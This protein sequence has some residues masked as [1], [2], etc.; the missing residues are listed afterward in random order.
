M[1]RRLASIGTG[2][3]PYRSPTALR[4][5]LSQRAG[6]GARTAWRA[7]YLLASGIVLSLRQLAVDAV[8]LL[9]VMQSRTI[10]R[11][12]QPFWNSQ[13]RADYSFGIVD[14]GA[15][16]RFAVLPVDVDFRLARE[17]LGP[18][19]KQ[20]ADGDVADRYGQ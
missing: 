14:I 3:P 16:Q 1:N 9:S 13:L 10:D 15:I 5:V 11:A 19:T 2:E 8:Y 7:F 17:S 4:G 12:K 20:Q 6:S 18:H